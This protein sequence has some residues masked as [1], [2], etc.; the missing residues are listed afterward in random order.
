MNIM[1]I[2][3][4]VRQS[5]V[6]HHVHHACEER[7]PPATV[8]DRKCA[9]AVLASRRLGG[10]EDIVRP[11]LVRVRF[12]ATSQRLLVKMRHCNVAALAI[13]CRIKACSSE[14]Y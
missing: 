2:L 14:Y 6:P 3:D 8:S 12:G 5:L 1:D 13:T 4:N 10:H 11:R 7:D 9:S